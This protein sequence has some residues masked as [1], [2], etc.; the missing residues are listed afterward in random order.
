[1]PNLGQLLQELRA[2]DALQ[3]IGFDES[4]IDD[5][6]RELDAHEPG[7]VSVWQPASESLLRA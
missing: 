4:D 3:G 6:L 7:Q 1:M 2:E 5:I